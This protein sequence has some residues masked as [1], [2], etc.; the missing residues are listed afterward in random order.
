MKLSTTK[1]TDRD[2]GENIFEHL[3]VEGT[4]EFSKASPRDRELYGKIHGKDSLLGFSKYISPDF[5]TPPHIKS[6]AKMLT[7]VEKGKIKRLI[8]NMPPR[9]GKSELCSKIFPVWY[10][11]RKPKRELIVTSYSATRAEDLTRWQRNTCED[12]RFI[13]VFPECRISQQT[14]A[15]DQWMTTAGGQVIGAGISGPITGRGADLAII[16]D[17]IKS[18][19]EAVSETIQESIWD[20]YRS[21]LFTRLHPGASVIVIMTR[22]VTN[23][24]A[25]RLIAEQG[26]KSDGGQWDI[27]KLPAISADGKALWPGRYDMDMLLEIRQS[28]G[29]KLWASLYQQEPVDLIERLFGDPVFEEPPRSLKRIAFL[30]PAFGGADFSALTFGGIAYD[31]KDNH[32]VYVTG[33]EIWRSQIDETYN[34]VERL[35]KNSGAGTLFVEVNQA[36][37]AVAAEFRRRGIPVREV[38]HTSNKHLRIVNAAK[39]NWDSLRFSKAV[40]QDY[41]TQLLSYS[42]L[43]RHD[44]AADSLAGLIESLGLGGARLERRF[45]GFLNSI[46]RR[47]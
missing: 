17:P 30:D 28:I 19:E 40:S 43:S 37:K 42:E 14:R 5:L 24:L 26:L 13:S 39:V 21:T 38:T 3:L 1:K 2:T 46:M 36:Q 9:H 10:L 7:D 16:D 15:K 41:M 29:E 20:W 8:I 6:I 23:D 47:W 31:D 35:Y 4:K 22:W 12:E 25:G 18:Y 11:G 27:L 44:D 45:D 33:G 34:R 32:T